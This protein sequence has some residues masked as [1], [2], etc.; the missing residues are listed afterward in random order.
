VRQDWPA[1]RQAYLRTLIAGAPARA[2]QT[3]AEGV[4]FAAA[5]MAAVHRA[6][7]P[8][9]LAYQVQGQPNPD[10]VPKIP[11]VYYRQL[12]EVL[13]RLTGQDQVK[14]VRADVQVE[15]RVRSLPVE[16]IPA[17]DPAALLA[18][19]AREVPGDDAG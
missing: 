10:A 19:W 15:H 6:Y 7:L 5:A 12:V 13:S 17:T 2:A 1:R 11:V 9:L 3:A 8:L 18:G 14:R 4:A 16:P